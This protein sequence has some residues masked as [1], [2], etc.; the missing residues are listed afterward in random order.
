MGGV[1]AMSM[2]LL[3]ENIEYEQ[4]LQEKT[5]DTVVKEEYVIPD[6]QPDVRKILMLDAKPIIMNKQVMQNKVYVEGQIKCNVLYM[7]NVEDT[8]EVYNVIYTKDFS[9]YIEVYGAQPDMNCSVECYVEHIECNIVNERKIAIEGILQLK[10]SIYK[11]YDFE[12]VKDI[13]YMDDI[14]LLKNP[15]SVDKVI[16]VVQGELIGKAHM[17][18]PMDKPE[19]GKVLKCD[20]IPHKKDVRLL[21]GKVQIEAFAHIS[22]LY[23]VSGSRE[24]CCLE[25]DVF[26]NNEVELQG[27]DYFM[28]SSSEFNVEAI[29]YDIKED[30]LGENRIVDVET[31]IRSETKVMYKAEL[32]M[33]E[34]AYSPTKVLE[35]DKKNYELNI[36]LGQNTSEAIIKENIEVEDDNIRPMEIIMPAG[37]VCITDKRIV[38]DKVVIEGLLNVNI[39][40]KTDNEDR[41]VS[42]MKEDIPFTCSIDIPGAKIDMM[43]TAQ[44]HLE[45]IEASIEANTIAVKA[46][47]SAYCKVNYTAHKEFLIGIVPVEDTVIKK[48]ASITIYVVQEGDTLWKIAKKYYTTIDDLVKINDIENPDNISVG[49]KLIIPGRTV[50]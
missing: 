13:D 41:Y 27:V 14:Q 26:I 15:S 34:D 32:D 8:N 24:L 36:M 40:Y 6:V 16:G 5:A 1:K 45:S 50:I 48:K 25:D 23:K 4:L 10:S 31:L 7:A 9:N 11:K 42:T 33:I 47:V 28:N 18:V 3:K 30:D 38:E 19:I 17:Q 44:V 21:E 39:L 29:E 12:V 20:V 22:L 37:K 46:I 35:M 49:Q 2:E 43:C